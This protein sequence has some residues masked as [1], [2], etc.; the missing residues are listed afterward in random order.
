MGLNLVFWIE[1][2][3]DLCTVLTICNPLN[4]IQIFITSSYLFPLNS[5]KILRP[6]N[7]NCTTFVVK[8]HVGGGF[9]G[10][11]MQH[12]QNLNMPR[13]QIIFVLLLFK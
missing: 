4:Y 9:R 10:G 8:P 13:N 6:L 3:V 7:I 5:C 11:L 2:S 12:A 1:D